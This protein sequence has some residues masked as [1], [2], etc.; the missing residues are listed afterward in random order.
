MRSRA[1]GTTCG[2]EDAS[3]S[4]ASVPCARQ[5]EAVRGITRQYVVVFSCSAAVLSNRG[6]ECTRGEQ[7]GCDLMSRCTSPDEAQPCHGE[8]GGDSA[9]GS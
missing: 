3:T 6:Q 8:T 9:D 2:L 7:E 4:K 1:H 5:C